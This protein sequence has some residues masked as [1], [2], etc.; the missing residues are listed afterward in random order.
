M[1]ADNTFGEVNYH[2]MKCITFDKKAQEA[3]PKLVRQKMD[4]DRKAAQKPKR[5]CKG[6]HA[7]VTNTMFCYCGEFPLTEDGTLTENDLL[8]ASGFSV[9]VDTPD[10]SGVSEKSTLSIMAMIGCFPYLLLGVFALIIYICKREFGMQGM[11]ICIITGILLIYGT[12]KLFFKNWN[13]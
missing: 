2:D 10:T 5:F 12:L 7:E 3:I 13:K 9:P 6:C 8:E 1:G 11:L 4:A